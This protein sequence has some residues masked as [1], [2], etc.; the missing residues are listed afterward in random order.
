[1]SLMIWWWKRGEGKRR[2]HDCL[3]D[4]SGECTKDAEGESGLPVQIEIG[5]GGG[6]VLE[7]RCQTRIEGWHTT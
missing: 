2:V 5:G 1:M 3:T 7:I 6:D 4:E